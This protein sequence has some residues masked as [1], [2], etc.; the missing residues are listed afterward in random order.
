[1]TETIQLH[2][3]TDPEV[4]RT[5]LGGSDIASVLGLSPFRTA[6]EVWLEKTGQLEPFSGNAATELGSL[7]ESIVAD[8][9][10]ERHG[11]KLQR[12]NVTARHAVCKWAF[13]HIDRKIVGRKEALEVKTTVV[14]DGWGEE[15]TDEIPTHILPQVH[16]QMW[17]E[18]LE[19]IH[20]SCWQ[21]HRWRIADYVVERDLEWDQ[22]IAEAGDAFWRCVEDRVEPMVQYNAPGVLAALSRAYDVD[23]SKI[24]ELPSVAQ[25][26]HETRAELMKRASELSSA[27]DAI[28]AELLHMQRDAWIGMLPDGTCYRRQQMKRKGY[29][30]EDTV[31]T[32][33]RH[34]KTVPKGA[35]SND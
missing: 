28:K 31:V 3:A 19:R 14:S 22:L 1:M 11:L 7:A 33:Y 21:M 12:K 6:F 10:A 30:I 4:R 16:H 9:F 25:S 5:G 34:L 23:T 35:S 13:A 32:D 15:G 17:V 20:V 27:A 2:P 24:V 18:D 8:K 29:V 26:L